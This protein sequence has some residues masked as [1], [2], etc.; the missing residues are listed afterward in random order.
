MTRYL[1]AAEAD[2]IQDLLFR[3][4]RLREVVGGSQ[5]LTRF[6]SEVPEQ[7]LGMP[8]NDII[9]SDGGSFRVVFDTKEDANTFGERL[10]EMYRLT[11]GGTLTLAKPVPVNG[12]FGKASEK[13]HEALRR[14]KRWPIDWQSRQAVWQTP[15]HM[16]YIAFCA[17]CGV[18]LAVSHLSIH[19]E[20]DAQYVCQSCLT[21]GIEGRSRRSPKTP[22]RERMGEFLAKF[23][24]IVA[25]QRGLSLEQL[26]W[27]GETVNPRI[28]KV[29]P[30]EDVAEYDPRHY[31]AYVVADGNN[32]GQVFNACHTKDELKDL[33]KGL[34]DAIHK[35]LAAP[36]GLL[37]DQPR[38]K[39][40]SDKENLVPVYP[41][42]LGGDDVFVLLPAPWALDFAW[43]F[44]EAYEEEMKKVT[45]G[46]KDVA[47][48]TIS[49]AVVICKSKHPYALAHET[50][51]RLLNQAKQMSK[52]WALENN[53]QPA[54][55]VNFEV[56]LGGR[57]TEREQ[58][59]KERIYATL[60]P[61]W[62]D[63]QSN[64]WGLSIQELINQRYKLRDVPRKRLVEL[65]D[66]YDPTN[67]PSSLSG[68]DIKPWIDGLEW[69]LQRMERYEKKDQP[70]NTPG[71]KM[72]EALTA[73][74]GEEKGYWRRISRL[75]EDSWYGHGLPD[76]LR[77]WDFALDL[78]KG[79]DEY[80]EE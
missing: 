48:P 79:R 49:V 63:D 2:K 66:L 39:I 10:A 47:V 62:A 3:S 65:R 35:A 28:G 6:C 7:Q 74:G 8:K 1:L 68:E 23:Y 73:L 61:Y 12:D 60:R 77:A 9:I 40:F 14:A 45:Q 51:E 30:L 70:D 33:S 71:G 58:P 80:E 67:L 59:A 41:L 69:V 75:A 34:T 5:L 55:T 54:S 37:M 15:A 46:L 38:P 44:A 21:K 76:L 36:T 27:P 24:Q 16:P 22:A 31:V 18:G 72:R 19:P 13:A 53:G 17:S 42:I 32:M 50:G 43:R 64:K 56:V 20:E 26:H 25:A 78:S 57:L 29:D 4:S 52:R 11:T